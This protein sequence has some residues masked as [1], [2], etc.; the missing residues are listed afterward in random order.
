MVNKIRNGKCFRAGQV[1][2]RQLLIVVDQTNDY[3]IVL[4]NNLKKR[5]FVFSTSCVVFRRIGGGYTV[6]PIESSNIDNL[7]HIDNLESV[8]VFPN[9]E[10]PIKY[11]LGVSE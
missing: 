7:V 5:K 3:N 1:I 10:V 11:Q 8:Y 4:K 9:Y 6:C 2:P